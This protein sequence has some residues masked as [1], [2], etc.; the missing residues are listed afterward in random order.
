MIEKLMYW[1]RGYLLCYIK[2]YSIERF[3]NLCHTKGI[4]VR[5]LKQYDGGYEFFLS[6]KE[7]RQIRPIARKTKTIP[8]I[9]KR[10]GLPEGAEPL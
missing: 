5:E 7:Y 3:I 1:L 8:Y 9:R 10:H 2:G 6:L 4:V